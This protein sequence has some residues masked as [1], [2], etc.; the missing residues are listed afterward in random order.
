MVDNGNYTEIS[1]ETSVHAGVEEVFDFHINFENIKKIMPPYPVVRIL[2][3]P[4][5]LSK[6]AKFSVGLFLLPLIGI[7]WESRVVDFVENR[8]FSDEQISVAPFKY[9]IHEHEFHQDGEKCR[10]V[11]RVRY[12][13]HFG[14]LGKI[15]DT[16][17]FRHSMRLFFYY[18]SLRL[19]RIFGN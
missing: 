19:Q 8:R 1:Y 9:W 10:I 14:I 18:R 13:M 12:K 17:F 7:Y 6:D 16:V 11:D 3:K 2:E 5:K 4:E 15:V